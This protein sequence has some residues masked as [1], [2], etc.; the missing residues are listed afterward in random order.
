MDIEVERVLEA[1]DR[2][3]ATKRHISHRKKSS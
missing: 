2:R 3:L 1:V